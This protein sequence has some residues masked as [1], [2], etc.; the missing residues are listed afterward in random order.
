MSCQKVQAEKASKLTI[1]MLRNAW[2][3]SSGLGPDTAV[4]GG[5]VLQGVMS[6]RTPEIKS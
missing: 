2:R 4:C 3:L 6:A 1:P 5:G